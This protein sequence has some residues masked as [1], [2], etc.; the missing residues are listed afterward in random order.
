MKIPDFK[1]SQRFLE[2][3]RLPCLV[4][5]VKN[6]ELPGVASR[7]IAKFKEDPTCKIYLR[8]VNHP[9]ISV[10]QRQI[11]EQLFERE[12]LAGALE[13]GM[14]EYET[15]PEWA[16]DN[17]RHLDE[18]S[19]SDI[20]ECG[21]A[22][23]VTLSDIVIDEVKQEVILVGRTEWDGNL[24][25]HGISIYLR[26]GRWRFDYA[27]YLIDYQESIETE[28]LTKKAKEWEKC[29]DEICPQPATNTQIENDPGF[30]R[31][32]WEFDETETTRALKE[33]GWPPARIRDLVRRTGVGLTY[34]F[35]P[36]KIEVTMSLPRDKQRADFISCERHGNRV[37]VRFRRVGTEE[38][39]MTRYCY[40]GNILMD[41]EGR[42]MRRVTTS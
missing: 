22:P 35:S 7:H 34:A 9:E 11:L 30:L 4:G 19:R 10:W 16:G 23:H 21:M 8:G 20:R 29:W 39:L 2:D 24:I 37:E 26:D 38:I 32:S 33:H 13:E 25:E 41:Y 15:N 17:Y 36:T 12:R 3:V 1:P 28:E 14:K 42:I 40:K 31:G 6:S 5:S 27:E 18:N